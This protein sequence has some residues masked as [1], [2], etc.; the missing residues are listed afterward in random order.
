[1][2]QLFC[3]LKSFFIED[4]LFTIFITAGILY[5][6]VLLVLFIRCW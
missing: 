3:K 1:M 5:L 6:I 4:K 2:A